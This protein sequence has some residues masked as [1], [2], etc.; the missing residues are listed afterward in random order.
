MSNNNT[1]LTSNDSFDIE[2]FSKILSESFT[3][4]FQECLIKHQIKK[5]SDET[6]LHT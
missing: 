1:I 4:Y 6:N 2:K 5:A 3:R